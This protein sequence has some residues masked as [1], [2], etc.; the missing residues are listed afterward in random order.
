MVTFKIGSRYRIG[1]VDTSVLSG[2]LL[3]FDDRFLEIS[4]AFRDMDT[5][6]SFIVPWTSVVWMREIP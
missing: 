5:A 6:V 2:T 3:R 1:L 4:G